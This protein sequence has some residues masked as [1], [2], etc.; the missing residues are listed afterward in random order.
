[1]GRG[2]GGGSRGRLAGGGAPDRRIDS[3]DRTRTDDLVDASIAG[4]SLIEGLEGQP[5]TFAEEEAIKLYTTQD[6]RE[7]N[8]ALGNYPLR[9]GKRVTQA[10]WNV[11]QRYIHENLPTAL[12][13]L[14]AYKGVSYRTI[15]IAPENM[16]KFIKEYK[17]GKGVSFANYV[18]TSVKGKGKLGAKSAKEFLE[19]G[20]Q[21]N[22]VVY[23]IHGKR[24]RDIRGLSSL[25]GK[26]GEILFTHDSNF[27]VRNVTALPKGGYH[28]T[29]EQ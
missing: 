17:P 28:I 23:T 27:R 18:S 15:E 19:Q 21:S 13:K 29:L 3:A 16:A 9:N 7:V 11:R 5:L 8:A 2:Q 22:I 24:G 1:M 25:G 26:E 20:G 14:P 12:S 6:Y 4:D 10:D